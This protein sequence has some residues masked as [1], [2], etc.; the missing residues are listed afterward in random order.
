V[1]NRK[2]GEKLH[3]AALQAKLDAQVWADGRDWLDAAR[4]AFWQ[5]PYFEH[6]PENAARDQNQR[7]RAYLSQY[8]DESDAVEAPDTHLGSILGMRKRLGETMRFY[9]RT[10]EISK[11]RGGTR[12]RCALNCREASLKKLR[13]AFGKMHSHQL[14][15]MQNAD[16]RS[17][18]IVLGTE[19]DPDGNVDLLA[20]VTD[21]TAARKVAERAYTGVLVSLDDDVV[22]DI[23]LVDSPVAFLEKRAA[24]GSEVICKLYDGLVRKGGNIEKGSE[25]TPK[26]KRKQIEKTAKRMQKAA[27]VAQTHKMTGA[28]PEMDLA[29]FKNLYG[30][31]LIKGPVGLRPGAQ[32]QSALGLL[33]ARAR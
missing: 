1:S 5:K 6:C 20:V 29:V 2:G 11:Q 3:P 18:G 24:A 8:L 22:S 27:E 26:Q 14:R 13:Q 21:P 10:S 33:T 16:L 9:G 32:P 7:A 19:V 23:S 25:V 4:W 30:A 12:I 28:Y 17:A 31:E 15:Q